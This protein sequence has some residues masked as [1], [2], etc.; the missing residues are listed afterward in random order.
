MFNCSNDDLR[1]MLLIRNVELLLLDACSQGLI[2]GT[3]HTCLGQ[4]YIP[5]TIREF[6]KESDFV[7]SN[8]RGHGHYLAIAQDTEGLLGEFLGKEG[9][10]GNGI[11]GSQHIFTD[12]FLSTGVQAEGIGAAAGIAW[13][14]KH[15]RSTDMCISY[16]GDGTFGRGVV[17]ESLNMA[18]LYQLPLVVVAE[19][20]G[21]AMTTSQEMNMAGT[22]EARCRAFGITY[23][24][25]TSNAPGE[26]KSILAPY[27]QKVR[28]GSGPLLIEFVTQRVAPHSKGDDTRTPEQ[29]SE[30]QAKYW[31][32]QIKADQKEY[33]LNVEAEVK[34]YLAELF[35]GLQGRKDAE[36]SDYV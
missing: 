25:L 17:Y 32:N 2:K 18:A 12:N 21:I 15:E 1:L 13:C 20:N 8:H 27:M 28:E 5:V 26:L 16:I 22:I 6:I 10:V 23:I 33:M 35:A 3:V 14:M 4:E 7:I 36:W 19:N 11:G 30:V 24:R 9:A 34:D 31:Y 29:L